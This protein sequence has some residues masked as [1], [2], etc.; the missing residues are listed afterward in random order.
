MSDVEEYDEEELNISNSDVVTKYKAAAEITNKTLSFVMG[1]CKPGALV[2]EV[3]AQGDALLEKEMEK[4]FNKPTKEGMIEKGVAFP[5]CISINNCCGHFSPVASDPTC[6]KEGDLVKIDVG[7]HID[8]WVAVAAHTICA[9]ED[10]SKPVK[11]RAADVIAAARD[12]FQVALRTIRPG[13]LTTEAS[14]KFEEVA[15]SYGCQMLDGV[16]THV[17]KRFILDG[18][19]V[20]LNKPTAEQGVEEEEF[21]TNEVFAIDVLVSTGDGKP[22]VLDE[23]QTTVYK[24]AL[25]REY[26][27]KMKASRA[28]F[29]EI[30]RKFPALP[31]TMRAIEDQRS[32]KLGLVECL[33]HELLHEYP[34]LWEKPGEMVAQF[35]S[36]V[37]LTS[38]G[39]DQLSSFPLQTLETD[40]KVENEEI[41]TLMTQSIKKAKRKGGK[42]KKKKASA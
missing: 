20:V 42:K 11:G 13:K 36:T 9:Q 27:L 10:P 21:E 19:K 17:Q 34:V 38:N 5:T 28:L 23:K 7:C 15:E 14:E 18:N 4:V 3:C 41:K 12:A 37:L 31:F 22:R 16:L 32:A 1:A 2:V 40:K 8:G 25:D 6:I 26:S 24:R 35:K 39:S 33:N 30:N 29:S